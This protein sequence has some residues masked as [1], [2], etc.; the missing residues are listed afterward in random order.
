MPPKPLLIIVHPGSACGSA[1][2]NLGRDNAAHQRLE[3]QLLIENWQGGVLVIDGAL[4]DELEPD[5]W[6]RAWSDLGAAITGALARAADQGLPS[7][8]IYGDDAED[9]NQAEAARQLVKDYALTPEN[10]AI[11]LTGAWIHDD[12]GGCVNH[13]RETLEALGFTLRVEDAINLDL[14]LDFD[15]EMDGDEDEVEEVCDSD[16]Q[17]APTSRPKVRP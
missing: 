9:F 14:D 13:V 17:P 4:S 5:G 11:T 8:R 7:G 3:M 2:E 6:R 1:D 16:A 12:G 15:D 10:A